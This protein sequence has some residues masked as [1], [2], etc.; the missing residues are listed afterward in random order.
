MRLAGC[1]FD[2]E[3]WLI[4]DGLDPLHYISNP[5][6]GARRI[7]VS[8]LRALGFKVGWDPLANN[9]HHAAVWGIGPGSKKKRKV[10]ALAVLVR[11]AKGET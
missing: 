4:A 8:E 3:D 9:R 7:K 2:V 6:F 11:K 10:A 1:Q 5:D